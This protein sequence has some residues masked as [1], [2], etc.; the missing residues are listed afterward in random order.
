MTR[1]KGAFRNY[2]TIVLPEFY[3]YGMGTSGER[4]KRMKETDAFKLLI[5]MA[6]HH[7]HALK[8]CIAMLRLV[9]SLG[10]LFRLLQ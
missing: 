5:M 3:E 10:G 4:Q 2:G 6:T 9:A 8:T 1:L 7:E